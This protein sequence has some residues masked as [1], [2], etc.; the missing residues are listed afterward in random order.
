MKYPCLV[1]KQFCKTEIKLEL[2]REGRNSYG[3]PFAP[4]QY[5]GKC[6][7]QDSAIRVLTDQKDLV[8]ITGKAL[9]PGDICPDL[10]VITSG[11]AVIFGVKRRVVKGTK[12]RNPDETVNFT[13]VMLQ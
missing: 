8:Q 13:E 7:Y 6:N 1:P 11:T 2:E 10:P 3:E 5:E 9:F 4:V 12:A